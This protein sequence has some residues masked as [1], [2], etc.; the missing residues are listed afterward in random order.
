M[1]ANTVIRPNMVGSAKPEIVIERNQNVL[2]KIARG[3]LFL[4]TIGK[5]RQKGRAGDYI[6]VEVKI[7]NTPRRIMVKVNED[8]FVEPL[9]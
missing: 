8:G 9:L 1:G 2:V 7:M 5:A 4:E 3:G 6:E